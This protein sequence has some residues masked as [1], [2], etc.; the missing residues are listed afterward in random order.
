MDEQKNEQ[1]LVSL[2]ISKVQL[3]SLLGTTPE[4]LSRILSQMA[5]S[6]LIEVKKRDIRILDPPG[7]EELGE[8]GKNIAE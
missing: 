1:G 2:N 5:D 8:H 3:S 7:L 6:G 4:T